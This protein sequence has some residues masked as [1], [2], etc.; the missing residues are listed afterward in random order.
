[1]VAR[2]VIVIEETS[3]EPVSP[4]FASSGTSAWERAAAQGHPVDGRPTRDRNYFS[5]LDVLISHE[6]RMVAKMAA[7]AVA[8]RGTPSHKA[9]CS[10]LQSLRFFLHRLETEQREL[11][12]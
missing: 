5:K 2:R 1:M 11:A 7:K 6:R 4:G 9:M 8:A 3:R 12:K 10:K